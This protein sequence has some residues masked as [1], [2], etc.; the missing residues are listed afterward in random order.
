MRR[1]LFLSVALILSAAGVSA[2]NNDVITSGDLYSPKVNTIIEGKGELSRFHGALMFNETNQ[3]LSAGDVDN[4]FWRKY[5]NAQIMQDYGQ[6]LWMI[7]LSGVATDVTYA[8]LHGWDW[9]FK[10]D[11]TV[12]LGGICVLLGGSLDLAGWMKLGNLAEL[13]NTDPTVRKS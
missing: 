11:P 1:L 4:R 3:Y 5:R 13:Y 10:K 8:L 9:D 7:G 6:Y 12:I 2:Q